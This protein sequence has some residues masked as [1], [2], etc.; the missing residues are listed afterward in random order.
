MTIYAC[1]REPVKVMRTF[2]EVR[3][4]LRGW[5]GTVSPYCR[6]TDGQT[7]GRHQL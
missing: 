2:C 6:R 4:W 7:D 5:H 3:S 1:Q